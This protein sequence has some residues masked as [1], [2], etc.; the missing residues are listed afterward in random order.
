MHGQEHNGE[1][2][3]NRGIDLAIKGE[4]L[5]ASSS[6]SASSCACWGE[7]LRRSK[8]TFVVHYRSRYTR[9][10]RPPLWAVCEVMT[11]GQLSKWLDNLQQRQDRR[12]VAAPYGIDEQVLCSFA[13]HL[14]YVRNLC[15]HHA[16]LYNRAFTLTVK[17]PQ[18]P[19]ALAASLNPHAPRQLYNT[20]TLMQYLMALVSPGHSWTVRLQEL[21]R[22]HGDVSP[23]AMG[24][25][26]DWMARP[27]RDAVP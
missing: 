17:L 3:A 22:Q 2:H 13:H 23:A 10:A 9:P 20:L 27:L 1:S 26:A 25:P 21:L 5:R 6:T 15:A 19:A 18:R 14:S 16:R 12:A 8:E 7:V 24:F 4:F 11:L